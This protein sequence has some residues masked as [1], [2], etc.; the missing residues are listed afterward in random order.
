MTI[1]KVAL[2]ERLQADW[3]NV[4]V[5]LRVASLLSLKKRIIA[6]A[7]TIVWHYQ[8]VA[9]PSLILGAVSHCQSPAANKYENQAL[10]EEEQKKSLT[11]PR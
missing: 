9:S 3:K 2:K 1:A 6:Q 7:W 4:Q 10:R 5:G 11:V 8:P